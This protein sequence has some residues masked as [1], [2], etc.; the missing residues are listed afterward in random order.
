MKF[1]GLFKIPE[2]QIVTICFR[3]KIVCDKNIKSKNTRHSYNPE[4]VLRT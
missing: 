4:A 3:F 2:L 1:L